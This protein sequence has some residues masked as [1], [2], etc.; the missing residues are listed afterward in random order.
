MRKAVRAIV[1][2]DNNL[3]VM[4]RNKFGKAYETLPGGAVDGNESLADA[5]IR[6]LMEETMVQV[7][8]PRLVFID[9]A[10]EPYGDQY[11]FLCEYVSGEPQ[12]HP[13][14]TELKIHKQGKN[15]YMPGWLPIKHLSQSPFVSE[16][17]KTHLLSA[18][19][20]GWPTVPAE[21]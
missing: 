3:L 16:K 15:L 19:R 1:I 9:H 6:E 5:L 12:L 2:V 13:N 10:G 7:A 18:L 8:N 21:F 4:R 20:E 11:V 17:L 14:S